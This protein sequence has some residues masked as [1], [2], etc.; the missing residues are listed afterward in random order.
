MTVL[1]E[2]DAARV[3]LFGFRAGQ[4]LPE[5][6]VPCQIMFQVLRGN[7][8]FTAAGIPVE[9]REG[10]LLELEANARHSVVAHSESVALLTQTPNPLA[11][12]QTIQS[13]A[14]EER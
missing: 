8:T 4:Q 3:V 13:D 12:R 9:L 10:M 11:Q 14:K 7:L 2:T 6:Q 5:H 1:S